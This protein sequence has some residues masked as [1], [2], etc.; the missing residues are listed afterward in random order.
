MTIAP[1]SNW[2]AFVTY[3]FQNVCGTTCSR[4]Y[5]GTIT[6][7]LASENKDR[8]IPF[9]NIFIVTFQNKRDAKQVVIIEI[10]NYKSFERNLF[11]T[12][13]YYF[14]SKRNKFRSFL[15]EQKC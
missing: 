13:Y 1:G 4:N 6:V 12:D 2:H 5:V 8:A 11:F 15:T 9:N 3:H 10:T 7:P 14:S